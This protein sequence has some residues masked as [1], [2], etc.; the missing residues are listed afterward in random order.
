MP[1]TFLGDVL[2]HC[3]RIPE[4]PGSNGTYMILCRMATMVVALRFQSFQT[5]QSLRSIQDVQLIGACYRR[6]S[7]RSSITIE[8]LERLEPRSFFNPPAGHF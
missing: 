3:G 8:L 2:S 7:R 5:F 1:S 6:G 4:A